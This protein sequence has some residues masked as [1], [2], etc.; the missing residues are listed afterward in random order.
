MSVFYA[1]F[2]LIQRGK[3][4]QSKIFSP[5]PYIAQ[6][7]ERDP[8][9]QFQEKIGTFSLRQTGDL[10]LFFPHPMIIML[11]LGP[12]NNGGYQMHASEQGK[13]W[14]LLSC[15]LVILEHGMSLALSLS[16]FSQ[17]LKGI[18]C[19]RP[20]NTNVGSQHVHPPKFW[21]MRSALTLDSQ[22]S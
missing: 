22:V 14:G 18:I 13:W 19:P 17:L 2:I 5:K 16:T 7:K 3:L 21:R 8:Q 15:A 6:K 1:L 9:F 10:S 4:K 11:M 20:N 12:S